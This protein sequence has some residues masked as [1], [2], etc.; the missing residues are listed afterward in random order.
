MTLKSSSLAAIS[1]QIAQ[2]SPA[3]STPTQLPQQSKEEEQYTNHSPASA[4]AA[5]SPSTNHSSSSAFSSPYV[6]SATQSPVAS[7]NLSL[8]PRAAS[9]FALIP[10][11]S[12]GCMV[13][14]PFLSDERLLL[15]EA[16]L[17]LANN[18][19]EGGSQL[20][21]GASKSSSLAV[22]VSSPLKCFALHNQVIILPVGPSGLLDLSSAWIIN[23][24]HASLSKALGP[25]AGSKFQNACSC[26]LLDRFVVCL[27]SDT[28]TMVLDG[29]TQLVKSGIASNLP[30]VSG[31]QVRLLFSAATY[32]ICTSVTSSRMETGHYI[33]TG[34]A[35]NSVLFC[36][37]SDPR[38]LAFNSFRNLPDHVFERAFIVLGAT[39]FYVLALYDNDG[40]TIDLSRS[41]YFDVRAAASFP[42][43]SDGSISRLLQ[44]SG[45]MLPRCPIRCTPKSF[46]ILCSNVKHAAVLVISSSQLE[47]MRCPVDLPPRTRSWLC[48]CVP[49]SPVGWIL[50][51]DS[52][53]VPLVMLRVIFFEDSNGSTVV[54][55][56]KVEQ[57]SAV[58]PSHGISLLGDGV[59]TVIAVSRKD[60]D[61]GN[62]LC[63]SGRNLAVVKDFA[64]PPSSSTA[65][66]SISPTDRRLGSL[67]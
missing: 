2:S 57:V 53:A 66:A 31:N 39:G 14:L 12:R 58:L 26:S 8:L 44:S 36:D 43:D 22:S 27:S 63:L 51:L 21:T 6:A 33:V 7:V 56:S 61:F 25:S 67:V 10:L 19:Q 60:K 47:L 20:L 16:L 15:G 64:S 62:A 54:A 38:N 65:S 42:V 34:F 32:A 45:G 29:D 37:V 50:C 48:S 1:R 40:D 46:S 49:P 13:V 5:P 24:E 17:L 4:A 9:G 35:T 55:R 23:I 52:E 30:P 59:N 11:R 18:V 41:L 3:K 28:T